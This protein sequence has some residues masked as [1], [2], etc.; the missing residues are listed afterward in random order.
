MKKI[1]YVEEIKKSAKDIDFDE[2]AKRIFEEFVDWLGK[3]NKKFLNIIKK[4]P[5]DNFYKDTKDMDYA[6]YVTKMFAGFKNSG[7]F[8][9]LYYNYEKKEKNAIFKSIVITGMGE[10]VASSALIENP[11]NYIKQLFNLAQASGA[12]FKLGYPKNERKY[13]ILI[14]TSFG[15]VI[16]LT[17]DKQ[18]QGYF[19]TLLARYISYNE[20]LY[21][22]RIKCSDKKAAIK[23]LI[24]NKFA[25]QLY[26][27]LKKVYDNEDFIYAILT[28]LDSEDKIKLFLQMIERNESYLSGMKMGTGILRYLSDAYYLYKK[29][30]LKK[31]SFLSDRIK[32]VK[33]SEKYGELF[34]KLIP[35]YKDEEE[36]YC[37]ILEISSK[38]DYDDI[39]NLV[40][41]GLK[42]KNLI[43]AYCLVSRAKYVYTNEHQ[44]R[45]LLLLQCAIEDYQDNQYFQD[46]KEK[47]QKGESL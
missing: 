28:Y 17:E 37:T 44:E 16:Y 10:D 18:N 14:E 39:V 1:D 11:Y 2:S 45:G 34:K 41:S 24:K 12:N 3:D 27:H 35:I 46:I 5:A 42:N 43:D 36:I 29:P 30:L 15:E 7:N 9:S 21:D 20:M 6:K 38:K 22:K 26:T 23:N 33:E 25:K 19:Q 31:I 8:Q 4:F 13:H 40:D 47:M 32:N